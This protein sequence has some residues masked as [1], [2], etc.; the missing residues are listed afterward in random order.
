MIPGR[1]SVDALVSDPELL[2]NKQKCLLLVSLRN[3]G[4]LWSSDYTTVAE[5]G[6]LKT[7]TWHPVASSDSQ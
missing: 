1:I 2:G 3:V 4:I 7:A 6:F 5:T